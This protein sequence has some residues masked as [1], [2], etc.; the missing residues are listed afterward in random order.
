MNSGH[1]WEMVDHGD[2]CEG[3][4]NDS[5]RC[6]I[7]PIKIE[8]PDDYT[9]YC[10]VGGVDTGHSKQCASN[11]LAAYENVIFETYLIDSDD[12]CPEDGENKCVFKC[13]KDYHLKLNTS[14]SNANDRN[15]K[16][17]YA[18]CQLPW[19]TSTGGIIMIK[20]NETT[21]AYI[22]IHR[23]HPGSIMKEWMVKTIYLHL[24]NNGL[25]K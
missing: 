3:Y 23:P 18:D 20:H 24:K 13:E 12:H 25:I 14:S 9:S 1:R 11:K 8:E 15:T 21:G 5:D 4:C 7:N 10:T 2:R 16:K 6:M 17:C 22:D 19:K